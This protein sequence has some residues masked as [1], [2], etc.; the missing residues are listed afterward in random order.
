LKLGFRA[1][2]VR[3]IDDRHEKLACLLV[4]TQLLEGIGWALSCG[5]HLQAFDEMKELLLLAWDPDHMHSCI[6]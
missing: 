5:K 6:D 2:G 3:E 1:L 4:L